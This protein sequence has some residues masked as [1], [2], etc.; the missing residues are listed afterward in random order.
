MINLQVPFGSKVQS[1]YSFNI[2]K[3]HKSEIQNQKHSAA[4]SVMSPLLV[5]PSPS[6]LTAL[7]VGNLI[8]STYID[9][10]DVI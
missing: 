1:N 3:V 10:R 4:Q 8:M 6:A 5:V 7:E 2:I 9:R